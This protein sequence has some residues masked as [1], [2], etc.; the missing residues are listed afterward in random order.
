MRFAIKGAFERGASLERRCRHRVA[1][2]RVWQASAELI[3]RTVGFAAL[4]VN[5]RLRGNCLNETL[6]ASL[7]HSPSMLQAWRD[8]Y[9]DVRPHSD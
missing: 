9:T 7:R 1:L 3:R 6:F 2:H 5:G 8:D 4:Q